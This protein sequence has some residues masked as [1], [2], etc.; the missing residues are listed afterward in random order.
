MKSINILRC[1]LISE[2]SMPYADVTSP[3][4]AYEI[5][6]KIGIADAADEYFYLICLSADGSV[7]GIHEISHGCLDASVVH[8][9][10]V[11]K[12][13]LLNNAA[14]IIV[15]HNHPSDN[16]KPSK[17]DIETTKRLIEA[18]RLLGI[19]LVDHIIVTK[20]G[21]VSFK[22]SELLGLN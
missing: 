13:A 11:F 18:G 1:N 5:L 17:V 9:R 2:S 8:P 12:R 6:K 16:L 22:S 19:P 10:E 21:F 4:D 3:L 15:A 14:K 20:S 7:A